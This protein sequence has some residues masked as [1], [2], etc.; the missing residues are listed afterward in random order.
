MRNAKHILCAL[1]FRLK[2]KQ[3]WGRQTN[4][5]K[6]RIAKLISLYIH[7]TISTVDLGGTRNDTFLCHWCSIMFYVLF[8]KLYINI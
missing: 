6:L 7:T 2:T 4:V 3:V 1:R 5:I 8:Y